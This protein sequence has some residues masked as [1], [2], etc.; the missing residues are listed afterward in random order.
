[1]SVMSLANFLGMK[2]QGVKIMVYLCL[3]F[4]SAIFL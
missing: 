2:K 4:F 1:M 3:L